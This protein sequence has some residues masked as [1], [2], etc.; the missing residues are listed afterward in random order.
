MGGE[1]EASEG[2]C[3]VSGERRARS[4]IP[5]DP[6]F[7]ALLHPTGDEQLLDAACVARILNVPRSWVWREARAGRLPHVR[8][9]RYL[10]FSRPSI[11]AFIAEAERGPTAYRKDPAPGAEPGGSPHE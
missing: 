2:S 4:Q 9:G 7:G 5:P 1:S 3:A 8:L 10:R 11:E 6:L